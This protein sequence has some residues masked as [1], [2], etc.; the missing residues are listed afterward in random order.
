MTYIPKIEDNILNLDGLRIASP[1][2][3]EILQAIAGKQKTLIAGD[4]IEITPEGRISAIGGGGDSGVHSF[5]QSAEY[6]DVKL[7]KDNKIIEGISTDGIHHHYLPQAFKEIILEDGTKITDIDSL[8]RLLGNNAAIFDGEHIELEKPKFAVFRF[9]GK[10]P[11]PLV[12][13]DSVTNEVFVE[14]GGTTRLHCYVNMAIQGHGSAGLPKKGYTFDPINA[15]GKAISIKFGDMISVDGFHYKA[16]QTDI[17]HC[18]DV[19]GENLWRAMVKSLDYPHSKVNNKILD[20]SSKVVAQNCY[21]DAKYGVDGFPTAMYLNDEFWGI[22]TLRLKKT[23]DNYAL[24][25]SDKSHIY[26]DNVTTTAF[27]SEPFD[28]TDWELRNP[29]LKGYE[30][31][32]EISDADVLTS[33]N[34]V[35]DW[36]NHIETRYADHADYIDLPL[37]LTY[38]ILIDLIGHRDS[39]GNNVNLLTWDATHWVAVPYDL[40]LTLGL[41]PRYDGVEEAYVV[42]S[43]VTGWISAS[44][45]AKF[46]TIFATEIKQL[47]AKMRNDGTLSVQSIIDHYTS[48]CNGI[49]R[50]AYDADLAKWGTL[51][52]VGYPSVGQI[53]SYIESRIAFLD[54]QWLNS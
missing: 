53:T 33:I 13:D 28:P 4:N 31:G 22:Y 44:I 16:Y 26:L 46:R 5:V 41:N 12:A 43:S 14:I 9:Y 36:L 27:L 20:M 25:K 49:P 11:N 24:E 40:D 30:A 34:R 1:T 47:Y 32:G 52:K 29:K 51:W 3:N 8:A 17:M 35:F 42:E 21:A 48:Q 39:N 7:D 2:I 37:W 23:R 50:W 54:S 45:W 18:R 10:L 19:G 6:V 38:V 15:N